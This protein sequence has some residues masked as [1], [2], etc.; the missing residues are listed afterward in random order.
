VADSESRPV[1]WVLAGASGAGKSSIGGEIVR[2]RGETYYDPD[3]A[4]AK[5]RSK[6]PG[7]AQDEADSH[8]W[9]QGRQLLEKAIARRVDF[10]FETTLGGTSMTARLQQ[11]AALGFDVKVWFVGLASP[12][13]HVQRVR[14]RHAHGGHSVPEHLIRKRYDATRQNLITLMPAL[15][16]LRVYDNSVETDPALG[17]TPTPQLLLHVVKRRIVFICDPANTPEWVKPILAAARNFAVP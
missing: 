14:S 11:A 2:A 8:A 10:T 1:I 7:L 16:A 9:Q 17:D 4:S 12:D 6:L 13:L 3:E 5:L 15:A